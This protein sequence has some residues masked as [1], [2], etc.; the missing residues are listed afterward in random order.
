MKHSATLTP[1]DPTAALAAAPDAPAPDDEN[2]PTTAADWERSVVTHGGGV[3]QTLADL[4]RGRGPQKDATKI[5]TA[6]RLS[7]EVIAF[8]KAGG[9]GWQTRVN[10]VL[11][12]YVRGHS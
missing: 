11:K 9:K 1:F 8:F 10:D 4:R 5:P 12:E 3:A 7:P 2:P 6:L